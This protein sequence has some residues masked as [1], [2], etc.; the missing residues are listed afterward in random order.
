MKRN[1]TRMGRTRPLI[2]EGL[3]EGPI[4]C[5]EFAALHDLSRN[6]VCHI[7]L[8][9]YDEGVVDRVDKSRGGTR[10]VEYVARNLKVIKTCLK[11]YKGDETV[12]DFSGLLN[13][14]R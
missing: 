5:T 7:L 8:E 4:N 9:L 6:R 10:R 11:D 14:W 12:S 2:L 13:V 1:P 3:M